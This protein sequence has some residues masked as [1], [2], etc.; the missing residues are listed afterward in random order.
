VQ[1][2]HSDGAW[3]ATLF[4]VQL[5]VLPPFTETLLFRG[6]LSLA[7]LGVGAGAM[8]SLSRRRIQLLEAKSALADERTRISRDMHDDVGARL[9]Q[10]AVMQD[11]FA[12]E[13]PQPADARL[14]LEEM[15]RVA[16]QAVASLDE[17]VWTVDPQNDTLASTAEYLAQYATSY[18]SPLK[19]MCR[20]EAPID[21][22]VVE[23]R[24]QVRHELILAFKEALQNI[25]K[26]AGASEVML[27]LR[28]DPGSFFV[29]VADNGGGLSTMPR[30][31]G[32]DGL[33]NM[34]A[35][36]AGVG[37]AC[38]AASRQPAGTTVTITI[39]LL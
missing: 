33:R 24:A 15:A 6:L 39:P 3:D 30:G 23:V 11:I 9:A 5:Q 38:G 26:H 20:Y 28:H 37:G 36:L 25:V 35:R 16:R 7:A 17:V 32:Q 27:T 22:P 10:L 14:S 12:R 4:R 13:Y 19:I 34:S 31:P 8:R 18:L 21:W 1:A 29:Q 2:A